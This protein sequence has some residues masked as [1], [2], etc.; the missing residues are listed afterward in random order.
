MSYKGAGAQF[1]R[2]THDLEHVGQCHG[3]PQKPA[4]YLG[5]GKGGG[6]KGFKGAPKSNTIVYLTG[7]R[8]IAEAIDV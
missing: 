3:L 5:G 2:P 1:C 6:G 4:I 7:L 8:Y